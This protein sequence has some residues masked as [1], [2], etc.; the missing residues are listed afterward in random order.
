MAPVNCECISSN[1][2]QECAKH[3][4]IISQKIGLIFLVVRNRILFYWFKDKELAMAYGIQLSI[5]RLG[6]V[7][8]FF[9][10][11]LFAQA[12]G[13]TWTLWGGMFHR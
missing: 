8:N 7:L 9:L 6:S 13:L 11:A 4:Q 2:C 5:T 10:T 3:K 1:L 12:Y